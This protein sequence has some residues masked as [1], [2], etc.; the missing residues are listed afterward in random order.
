MVHVP[1]THVLVDALA[2]LP[3]DERDRLRRSEAKLVA[4]LDARG[5]GRM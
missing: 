1:R 5:A 4:Y 3:T 2:S